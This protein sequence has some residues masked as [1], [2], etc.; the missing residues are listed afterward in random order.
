[1]NRYIKISLLLLLPSLLA[2]QVHFVNNNATVKVGSGAN[3]KLDNGSVNNNSGGQ[4]NNDGNIYLDLDFVQNT[5]ATYTGGATSWLWFE[6]AG[7]QGIISDAVVNITQLRVDNGN[8]VILASPVT[9]SQTVDLMS[10]STGGS[11][12]LGANNLVLSPGAVIN[13]YDASNYIIT[14]SVGVLQREVSAGNVV[15]PVGNSIYNPATL[16]NAGTLDNFMVRV[17]DQVQTGYPVGGIETDGVVGKVWM[18][19]E[20]VAG[21]SDVTMTL[22]WDTGDE[23]PNFDRSVSGISHWVGASWDRSPTW[24]PA[25]NV[26][27]TS[28]T[29]T[30]NGINSFSPFAVEDLQQDLPV[31]LISFDAKRKDV[32]EVVLTWSTATEI[33]NQGFWVQRMLEGELEFETIGW[34]DGMG[35]STITN[36]YQY[37]DNNAFDGVSYYRLQQ[38]DFD[39]YTEYTET[40]AVFGVKA[41]TDIAIYPNPTNAILNIRF[42][43]LEKEQTAN[44]QILDARGRLV[45]SQL[46]SISNQEILTLDVFEKYPSALYMLS[47]QVDNNKPFIKKIVKE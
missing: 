32:D 5:G 21:G 44:V 12:E 20:Q 42:S 6:G 14:N 16:N 41:V 43:N 23:L 11:I 7:N 13:N 17:E 46:H 31:E 37:I 27:G 36:N 10:I 9:V 15:F 22:Q 30:R 33:N 39:G 26:G 40:R 24:I 38:V 2:A 45:Y 3:I 34:V 18:I 29:Q 19:D 1:M 47:V 25:T 4:I 35:N 8:R 28:W